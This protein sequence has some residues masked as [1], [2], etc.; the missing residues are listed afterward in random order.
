MTETQQLSLP[1]HP[2]A[3]S[4]PG[5]SVSLARGSAQPCDAARRMESSFPAHGAMLT[6]SLPLEQHKSTPGG[7]QDAGPMLQVVVQR[8][9]SYGKLNGSI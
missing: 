9:Q 4:W 2:L 6:V 3:Q 8:L 1:F 5:Q 7:C